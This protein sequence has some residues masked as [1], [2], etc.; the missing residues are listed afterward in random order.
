MKDVLRDFL[1]GGQVVAS[2]AISLF[3]VRYWRASRDRF[4]VLFALAFLVLAA[5]W[6]VLVFLDAGSE[7]R[8]ASYLLRLAAFSLILVAVIDKNRA[9]G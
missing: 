1:S 7:F 3:F 8:P 5:H 9:D 6:T 4:F 2:L